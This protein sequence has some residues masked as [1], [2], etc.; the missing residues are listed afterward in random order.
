MPDLATLGLFAVGAL[1]ILLMPGPAVLYIVTCSLQR[2]WRAG[3]VSALGVEVGGL[4]HVLAA[5]LGLSALLI[6]SAVLLSLV[7]GLG[8][9]YL[10]YL[11]GHTLLDG[12]EH[13]QHHSGPNTLRQ[14][15]WQGALIDALNPKT[16]LFFLA[17]LPQFVRP[18]N[19]PVAMQ[20]LVLGLVF[21][22]LAVINDGAYAL[23]AS[24]L[25]RSL[26]GNPV[27]ARRWRYAASGIYLALGAG[28]AVELLG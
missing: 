22:A 9:A 26:S 7:K 1:A 2:G 28:A 25:R 4:F 27:F 10:I 14:V 21:L 12:S 20:T 3:L 23:L 17:F 11:G 8:A 19:G 5:T 15:F 18:E 24:R 16:A 13:P 6:S